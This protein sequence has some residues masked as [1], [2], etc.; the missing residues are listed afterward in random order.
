METNTLDENSEF[1]NLHYVRSTKTA[2]IQ[3]IKTTQKKKINAQ[4]ENKIDKKW[5]NFYFLFELNSL[6]L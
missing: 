4:L 3:S 1:F 2:R 5:Q 6:L